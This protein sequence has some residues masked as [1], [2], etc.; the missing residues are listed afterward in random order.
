MEGIRRI[1]RNPIYWGPFRWKGKVYTGNHEPL[2]SRDLFEEVQL[3]LRA[4]GKPHR[5]K[6]D[7]AF[8]GLATCRCGKRMVGHLA[9]GRYRY[10]GCSARCGIP[11]IKESKLSKMFLE[12]LKAIRIDQDVAE[13][14]LTAIK[15]FDAKR[16]AEREQTLAK[17]Q[18]R[19][20]QVQKTIDQAYDDKLS[21]RINEE[22]WVERFNRWQE[23]LAAVRADIRDLEGATFDSFKKADALIK[24]CRK[25]PRLYE[26]Q[27]PE[28][29]ARLIKLITSNFSWDGVN[30][31]PTYRKPF[32]LLAEGLLIMDGGADEIR[33]RDL[34]RDRP[35]F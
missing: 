10:Y 7:F 17:H 8:R 12:H 32:D 33:T 13:W 9:K 11:Q 6:H 19:Q 35:A 14:L 4:N 29:Q 25:A 34:R 15:E 16:Q 22:Y 1:L 31:T 2:I 5:S 24:L 20:R 30:L 21:G 28:E 27:T 23:E 3:A 26:L 18:E